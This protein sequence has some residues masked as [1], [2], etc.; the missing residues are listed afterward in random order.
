MLHLKSDADIEK[1]RAAGRIAAETLLR[2]QEK[3]AGDLRRCRQ[4]PV[5]CLLS[6]AQSP[7]V[8][9]LRCESPVQLFSLGL[10]LPLLLLLLLTMLMAWLPNSCH[11]KRRQRVY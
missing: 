6:L 1:I 11:L 8:L 9:P 2:V 5:Y 7:P 3:D 4:P 10:S